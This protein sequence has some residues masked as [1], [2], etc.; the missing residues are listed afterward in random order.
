MLILFA[1]VSTVQIHNVKHPEM[2][3]TF[4]CVLQNQIWIDYGDENDNHDGENSDID[5]K[6]LLVTIYHF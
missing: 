6:K 4:K 2:K 1:K 3:A 5:N